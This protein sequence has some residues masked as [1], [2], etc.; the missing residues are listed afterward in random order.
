MRADLGVNTLNSEVGLAANCRTP[1]YKRGTYAMKK[2]SSQYPLKF[3][4]NTNR[5]KA[6]SEQE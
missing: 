3:L 5:G 6:R 2:K 1:F 4:V